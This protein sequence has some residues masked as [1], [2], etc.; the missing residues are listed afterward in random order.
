M[1]QNLSL[2]DPYSSPSRAPGQRVNFQFWRKPVYQ[3]QDGTYWHPGSDGPTYLVDIDSEWS[4]L[5]LGIPSTMPYT[6]GKATVRARKFRDVDKKKAAGGDGG[7]ITIHGVEPS[8]VEIELMIWT[9]E[10]LRQ[11]AFLWPVL[12]PQ[13]YKG[14]PPAY[15]VQHPELSLHGIKALQFVDGEGPEL[16]GR[17]GGI[18]RMKAWEFLKPSTKSTTKTEVQAIGSLLDVGA[19]QV[20]SSG[21]APP[22]QNAA[23]LGPR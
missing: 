2:I 3:L 11:L 7:R 8:F 16:D 12:F 9:P 15:D 18:F 14:S 4:Y 6:P 23:N 21:Y 1:P 5:Y 10:Q 13:A 22:G 20:S 17:G 19:V